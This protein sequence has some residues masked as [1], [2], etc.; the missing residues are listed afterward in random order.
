MKKSTERER[1]RLQVMIVEVVFS[2]MYVYIICIFI[3][4]KKLIKVETNSNKLN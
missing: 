3:K 2:D 4:Y 1:K